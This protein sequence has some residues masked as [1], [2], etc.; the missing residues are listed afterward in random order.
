MWNVQ[1]LGFTAEQTAGLHAREVADSKA[2]NPRLDVIDTG[3]L[4]GTVKPFTPIDLRW[5]DLAHHLLLRDH[6]TGPPYGFRASRKF[7][8]DVPH[9]DDDHSLVHA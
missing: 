6:N 1:A 2:S 4:L 9:R 3:T 7:L 5:R 8:D